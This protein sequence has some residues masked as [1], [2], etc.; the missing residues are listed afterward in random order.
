MID[1]M[2]VLCTA[3]ALVNVKNEHRGWRLERPM[4][5]PLNSNS[6]A[7]ELTLIT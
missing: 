3:G 4:Q 2:L 1:S 6:I 5:S 7:W